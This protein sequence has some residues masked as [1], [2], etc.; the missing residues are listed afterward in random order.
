MTR[1]ADRPVV[2]RG[3]H[4]GRFRWTSKLVALLGRIPDEEVALRAG[5]SAP[6]V[7]DERS[8]RGIA[9]FRR[10]GPVVT[11]TEAMLALLG[12]DIDAAVADGLG[13][14]AYSVNHRRRVLGIP[15]YGGGAG[16]SRSRVRWRPRMLALLGTASDNVVA[17]RLGLT[18]QVVWWKRQ[19]LGIR[20]FAPPILAVVWPKAVLSGLGR[21]R[22]TD[23]A[24]ELGVRPA[25]VLKKREQLGIPPLRTERPI[26]RTER[27]KD[28]LVLP[29]HVLVRE[30]GLSAT[31]IRKL[32][33]E[34]GVR[35]PERPSDRWTPEV[36][37]RLGREPDTV[38]ARKLGMATSSV[39]SKRRRLGIPA[40]PDARWRGRRRAVRQGRTGA[41]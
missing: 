24:R 10:R 28:L 9:S 14:T 33:R 16:G 36:L 40:L 35:D 34:Y 5:V 32:R 15:A 2:E 39:L 8:R 31:V 18:R 22:D 19:Q 17:K 30:H 20:S 6:T 4:P 12:T 21:R 25:T 37:A 27:L 26:V 11:W 29:S 3:A 41:R 23:I 38:I 1:R 13:L 7:R